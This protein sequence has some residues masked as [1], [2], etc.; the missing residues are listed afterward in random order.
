M[1][2]WISFL[3]LGTVLVAHA[4]PSAPAGPASGVYK[5]IAPQP[6]ASQAQV[7]E[8]RGER[9]EPQPQEWIAVLRDPTA[10]GGVREIAVVD[11]KIVSDRTPLKAAAEIADDLPIPRANLIVDSDQIFRIAQREA[12]KNEVGFHWVDYKLR[13]DPESRAAVWSVSMYDELGAVVG[14]MKIS[15]QGG[16]LVQGFTLPPGSQNAAT[17][18]PSG[19]LVGDTARSVSKAAKKAQDSA[20]RFI[21]TLQE[22][23]VGERTIGPK[24]DQ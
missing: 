2:R 16:T 19:G 6:Y 8:I 7:V 23:F 4:A 21:G 10:R 9:A 14:S 11:G 18:S 12:V 13:A 20:L 15:A 1:N 5:A 24:E 3:F 22:E 17:P